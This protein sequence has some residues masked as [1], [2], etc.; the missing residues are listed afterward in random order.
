MSLPPCP[1][2]L[3]IHVGILL[4]PHIPQCRDCPTALRRHPLS[5][6]SAG[7]SKKENGQIGVETNRIDA[8]MSPIVIKTIYLF[9]RADIKISLVIEW[10]KSLL[11]IN[12]NHRDIECVNCWKIRTWGA[13]A[14]ASV[15]PNWA[16]EGSEARRGLFINL[17]YYSWLTTSLSCWWCWS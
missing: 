5:P 6:S 12:S 7:N 8:K 4:S 9:D 17:F 2:C 16:S 1:F 13:V 3:G 15:G 10:N 14:T 11:R